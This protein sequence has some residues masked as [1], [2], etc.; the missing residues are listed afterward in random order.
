LETFAVLGD[1]AARPE[2]VLETIEGLAGSAESP[3]ISSGVACYLDPESY[4]VWLAIFTI[5]GE[6]QKFLT[7]VVNPWS[8]SKHARTLIAIL[9]WPRCE[10]R[11]DTQSAENANLYI[12]EQ[13]YLSTKS[14]IDLQQKERFD[15]SPSPGLFSTAITSAEDIERYLKQIFC[16]KKQSGHL[17]N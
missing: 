15:R 10:C 17:W 13:T 7:T 4:C 9:P 14:K 16:L 3:I 2:F 8:K 11:C 6:V 12:S 5:A 1:E